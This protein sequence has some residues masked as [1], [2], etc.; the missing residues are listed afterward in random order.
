MGIWEMLRRVYRVGGSP[1][2]SILDITIEIIWSSSK[3]YTTV[4]HAS[5]LSTLLLLY[6]HHHY[7]HYYYNST[8]QSRQTI[9]QSPCLLQQLN[10]S[11]SPTSSDA[12]CSAFLST[13]SR[14]RA[15]SASS[16][17]KH[18]PSRPQHHASPRRR[19]ASRASR[20]LSD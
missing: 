18:Q 9:N 6:T 1:P 8:S 12:R 13:R 19:P 10:T 5:S 11:T 15:I 7:Q 16:L 17:L 2:F 20:Q 4:I 3:I 14:P